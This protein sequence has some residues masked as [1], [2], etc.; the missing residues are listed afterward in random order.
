MTEP[1]GPARDSSR[2]D[3]KAPGNCLLRTP[4]PRALNVM[5]G[6]G[7]RY[8]GALASWARATTAGPYGPA[9]AAIYT[10]SIA[11]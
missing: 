2:Q 7:G 8:P 10:A 5:R 4:Q 9:L 1:R 6:G 3:R 11:D